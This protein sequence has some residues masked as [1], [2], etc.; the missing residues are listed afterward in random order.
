MAQYIRV[1]QFIFHFPILI[2]YCHEFAEFINLQLNKISNFNLRKY[3][4]KLFSTLP[5]TRFV[6]HT[7]RICFLTQSLRFYRARI[8][9]EKSRIL[10]R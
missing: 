7:E 6:D 1:M 5:F 2:K 4:N 3:V 8:L 9:L 10:E